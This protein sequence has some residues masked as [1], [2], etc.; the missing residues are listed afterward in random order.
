MKTK[1]LL[2]NIILKKYIK[3]E[4]E[5]KLI[6]INKINQNIKKMKSIYQNK[7]EFQ[8]FVGHMILNSM[9]TII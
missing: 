1:L 9:L 4:L 5:L 7:E 2:K 8:N 3:I 6:I